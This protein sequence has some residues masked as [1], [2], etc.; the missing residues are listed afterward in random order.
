MMNKQDCTTIESLAFI[1]GYYQFRRI[2]A[3]E[4]EEDYRI[5]LSDFI[6]LKNPILSDRIRIEKT[7]G[8]IDST[9]PREFQYTGI[10]IIGEPYGM[11]KVGIQP[12]GCNLH[13]SMFNSFFSG[14]IIPCYGCEEDRSV[15]NGVLYE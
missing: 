11:L 8:K 4:S 14:G 13:R 10:D 12:P 9:V 7:Y 5:H 2:D 3:G 1:A 15:C 6:A